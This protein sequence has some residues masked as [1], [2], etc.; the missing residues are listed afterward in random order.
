MEALSP[1]SS[2]YGGVGEEAQLVALGEVDT[3]AATATAAAAAAAAAVGEGV[4]MGENE[5]DAVASEPSPAPPGSTKS[6]SGR[7]SSSVVAGE[8]SWDPSA[9]EQYLVCIGK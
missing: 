5:G 1:D 3:A 9:G 6:V 7:S 8:A 2:V 4:G